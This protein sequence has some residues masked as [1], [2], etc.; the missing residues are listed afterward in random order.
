MVQKNKI[1][2]SFYLNL[3]GELLS[4]MPPVVM[5]ILNITPDSFYDGGFH[6]SER[7]ILEKTEKMLADGASIIDIGGY[8][9]RP[10]ADDISIDEELNRVLPTIRLLIKNFKSIKISVDTFRSKV[11]KLALNEGACIINDISGGKLDAKMWDVLAEFKP[12]YILMHS[13]G[14]PQTMQ[15]L[16]S[17]E[18]LIWDVTDYFQKKINLLLNLGL[19]DIVIDPGFGF[20]KTI[21][22]NF[23]LFQ[24]IPYLQK[25]NMPIMVGISRKSMIYKSL[26]L[27]SVESLNGTTV[28]NTLALTKGANI[29]RVHDVKE[30]M[31][32]IK[33]WYLIQK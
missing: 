2:Q 32:A 1:N 24:N 4:L 10:M 13:R 18:D 6:N 7:G 12:V 33:L 19:K 30:A 3:N 5:G 8:S 20:A 28:L 25:L 23:E 26:G 31:E 29:L 21:E 27:N 15:G 17:Y 16:A 11:A 9:T 22:Q 14:N